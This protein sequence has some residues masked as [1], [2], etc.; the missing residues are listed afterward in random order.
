MV[1]TLALT[2]SV[3]L[4][5][6]FDMPTAVAFYC[7]VLG[8]GLHAHSDYVETAEGRFFH[9]CWL[10]N[11]GAEV[12]LNTAYDA[13]ERPAAPDAARWAAH[14]DVCLSIGCDDVEALRA[15]LSQQGYAAPP[16]VS[17]NGMR[18]VS[19]KDPDGYRLMF[20]QDA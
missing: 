5:Q 9:W 6:V 8:F 13:G 2:G 14:G 17:A 10:R 1:G 11:G 19:I 12:M 3:P 15:R 16:A 20:S 18:S 4:F 7:D